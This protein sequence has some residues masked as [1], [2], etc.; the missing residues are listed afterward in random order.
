MKWFIFL[1]LMI[2]FL[3]MNVMV[4]NGENNFSNLLGV[5]VNI[6]IFGGLVLLEGK[7]LIVVNSLFC[8]KDY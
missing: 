3:L 1:L 5:L 4:V 8:D 6:V 7:L 2:Y